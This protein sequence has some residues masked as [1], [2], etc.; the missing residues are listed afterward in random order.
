MNVDR[1]NENKP[2]LIDFVRDTWHFRKFTNMAFRIIALFTGNQG[3]K[4]SSV[5]F[6]Y[7]MRVLGWHPIPKKN[8]VYAECS[9]RNK[10]NTAPHGHHVLKQGGETVPGYEKGTWVIHKIPKDGKCTFCGAPIVIH[11]RHS[12]KIRLASETLPGDK[13]S[14]SEDGTETAETKNTIY[15]E[16]KKWLPPYLIKR[17]ITFRNP[18]MVVIDPFAGFELNGTKNKVSD[19]VFDFVSYSQT[20]QAGA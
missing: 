17:D 10:D 11:Q 18:A 13:E 6:Q 12:K 20:V 4:T 16:L 14:I 5:C 19:I 15:P 1:Y 2:F 8:V 3:M 7:V 9:T